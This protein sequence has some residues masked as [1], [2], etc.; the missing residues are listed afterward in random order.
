MASPA[1]LPA[2]LVVGADEFKRQFVIERLNKQIAKL[3]DLD[4]NREVFQGASTDADALVTSCNTLPF[5][6]D[7]RLVM[8]R[9]ADKMPKATSEAVVSYLAA[10]S[11]TTILCL[12]ATKLAKNTRLYKAV[13]KVGKKAVID[14]APKSRRD[15]PAQVRDFALSNGVTITQ[16][17]A[18]ELI[19]L[20]GESTV[21]LDAELKK[22]AAV[23]GRGTTIDVRQVDELVT[24][25]SEVKPWALSDAIAK[26]DAREAALLLS[27]M[28][29]QSRFG[30]LTMCL[31]RI[32]ELLV[33]KDLHPASARALAQE[34]GKQEWQVRNLPRWAG[35]FTQRELEGALVKG[36]DLD[37][38]MKSGGDQELLFEQWVLGICAR[39]AHS[40]EI[41]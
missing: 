26:R 30:L 25:T 20:V 15:L 22:M 23:L 14:C 18:E 31:N 2:Y 39:P 24:R 11:E 3:G 5:S 9:D 12:E 29:D 34:L 33:A 13:A 17:G 4:F 19:D 16:R 27:R 35:N 38:A 41:G 10:P 37:R 8:V 6:C 1:F 28:R 32:R 7:Y 40:G 36:A 21:H